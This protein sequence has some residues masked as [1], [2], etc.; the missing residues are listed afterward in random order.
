MKITLHYFSCCCWWCQTPINQ[1]TLQIN[2]FMICLSKLRGQ[3]RWDTNIWILFGWMLYCIVYSG[4]C[5]SSSSSV[6]GSRIR[7]ALCLSRL[8]SCLL[9]FSAWSRPLDRRLFSLD[10]FSAES[11]RTSTAFFSVGDYAPSGP[12][13]SSR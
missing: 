6:L 3:W 11:C 4:M 5:I 13:T 12:L 2:T 1:F 9:H 8:I 10:R 7:L